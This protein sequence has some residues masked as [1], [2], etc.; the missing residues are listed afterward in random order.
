MSARR[1][2]SLV[3]CN[4]RR[5]FAMKIIHKA[6]LSFTDEVAVGAELAL[7]RKMRHPNLLQ[8]VDELDT[9]GQLYLV[10]DL[11][12]VHSLR[13]SDRAIWQRRHKLPIRYN[14]RAPHICPQNYQWRRRGRD[15]RP[16]M[17]RHLKA[18]LSF[19]FWG[20][21]VKT[22]RLP[23][24]GSAPCIPARGSAPRPPR[25]LGPSSNSWISHDYPLPWIDPQT[26][27]PAS[28][29]CGPIRPTTPNRIHIQSSVLPQCTGQTD[30]H[31]DQ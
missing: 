26:Q 18:F 22:T 8:V 15:G 5:K 14:N 27:L 30:R 4:E 21:G 7:M 13:I 12:A 9:A 31:T 28:I 1:A 19:S 23:S 29:I 17:W 25:G 20:G 16:F 3:R 11:V 6:R 24:G 2:S 10:I